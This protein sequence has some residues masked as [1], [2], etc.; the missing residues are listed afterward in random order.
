MFASI[1][2]IIDQCSKKGRYKPELETPETR[3][4]LVAQKID[5]QNKG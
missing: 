1:E 2:L 5:I 3:N 4:Y